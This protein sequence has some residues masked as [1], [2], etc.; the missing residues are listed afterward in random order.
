M[1]LHHE[2][3]PKL[4]S[5]SVA[6]IAF[7]NIILLLLS[8]N[9][10]LLQV[11]LLLLEEELRPPPSSSR[12]PPQLQDSLAKTR[13]QCMDISNTYIIQ[14]CANAI[15]LQELDPFIVEA[16]REYYYEFKPSNKNEN[17]KEK[18]RTSISINISFNALSRE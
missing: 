12:R 16:T 9:R 8:C 1:T 11:T 4:K 17:S 13:Y 7:Q 18:F 14:R 5:I 10:Q 3:E 2:K 15:V 6:I